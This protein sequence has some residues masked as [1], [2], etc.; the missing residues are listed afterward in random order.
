M[1]T[2][3]SIDGVNGGKV[4]VGV[5]SK[6]FETGFFTP[7]AKLVFPEL[8]ETFSYAIGEILS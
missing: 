7:G 8:R 4:I 5:V 6:R 3:D 1:I 2:V